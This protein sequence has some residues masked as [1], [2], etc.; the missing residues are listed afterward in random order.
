[1]RTI[2]KKNNFVSLN[3]RSELTSKQEQWQKRQELSEDSLEKGKKSISPQKK[4]PNSDKEE[5]TA[6]M[7]ESLLFSIHHCTVTQIAT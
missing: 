6:E 3:R 5:T 7:Y 1:M 2:F 4:T